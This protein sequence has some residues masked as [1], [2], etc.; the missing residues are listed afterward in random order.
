MS[1][2]PLKLLHSG[3]RLVRD[4]EDILE[5][6]SLRPAR[7]KTRSAVLPLP[8]GPAVLDPGLDPASAP[9]R[10]WRA[11]GAGPRS[12]DE[13]ALDSGLAPGDLAAVVTELEL[14]GVLRQ[15]PGARLERRA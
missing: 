3:A 15:L 14:L 8:D 10:V 1:Q 11:L 9:G 4:C 6:L 12:L 7:P 2:G 13:L 5:E